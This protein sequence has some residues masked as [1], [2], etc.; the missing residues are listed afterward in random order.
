MGINVTLAAPT[1]RTK[2]ILRI[3]QITEMVGLS[4]A[5]IYRLMRMSRFPKSITIG[6][7]A[8]GWLESEIELWLTEKEI[9]STPIDYEF[10]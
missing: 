5:S 10:H 2:R 3:H 6:I 8:V 4:R 1:P 9:E 7:K